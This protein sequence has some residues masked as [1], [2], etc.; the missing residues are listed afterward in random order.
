[1]AFAKQFVTAV[2]CLLQI[3]ISLNPLIGSQNG[4]PQPANQNV[5]RESGEELLTLVWNGVQEAQKRYS[6]GC[7]SITEVRTSKLLLHPMIFRGRLCASGIDKFQM[8]YGEPDPIRLVFNGK[9]LNVTTGKGKKTTEILEIGSAV[10]K[11]RRYFSAADSLINLK[12]SFTIRIDESP[13]SYTM[14]LV[15]RSRQFKQR[16]NYVTVEL[17]KRDFLLKTLEIDGKSGVNSIFKLEF[18]ELNKN[19]NQDVFKVIMP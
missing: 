16:V 3:I 11:T 8:E 17:R 1:M 2:L 14:K 13:D 10:S 5:T 7:G 19:I 15:P 9:Y 6:T 4:A 18:N 12:S